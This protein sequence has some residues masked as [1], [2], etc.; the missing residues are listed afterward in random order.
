MPDTP[1][2]TPAHTNGRH[3]PPRATRLARDAGDAPPSRISDAWWWVIKMVVVTVVLA[4]GAWIGV[5][6]GPLP[7]QEGGVSGDDGAPGAAVAYDVAAQLVRRGARGDSV[8]TSGARVRPGDPFSLA[9]RASQPAFVY[10]LDVDAR[11]EGDL[12][13]P[14][15]LLDWKN[16]LPAGTQVLLPGTRA[17]AEGAWSASAR[18][19]RERIVVVA[20]PHAVPA[21][22]A[23]VRGLHPAYDAPLRYAHVDPRTL[24]TVRDVRPLAGAEPGVHGTWARDVTLDNAGR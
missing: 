17:G 16:P 5:A 15:P 1:P 7:R 18:S 23:L 2:P 22:D 21:L 10:V 20:S 14:H 13:F 11:G 24:A 4:G 6:L 12:L 19:G 9:W 8:L 3:A